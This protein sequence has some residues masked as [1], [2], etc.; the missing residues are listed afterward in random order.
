MMKKSLISFGKIKRIGDFFIKNVIFQK[1]FL[2]IISRTVR[3]R[4]KIKKEIA[5]TG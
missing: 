2:T 3:A 4:K 1:L 5:P